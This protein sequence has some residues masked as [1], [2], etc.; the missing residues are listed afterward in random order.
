MITDNPQ[1]PKT[2][3]S[4]LSV[5]V[6]S[7]FFPLMSNFKLCSSL[8][9]IA[10]CKVNRE[11]TYYYSPLRNGLYI[12]EDCY[13]DSLVLSHWN[14][15]EIQ[16]SKSDTV[17]QLWPKQHIE[18]Q[19]DCFLCPAAYSPV[20]ISHSHVAFFFPCLKAFLFFSFLFCHSTQ[21]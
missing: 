3:Y 8:L 5:Y 9:F 2:I 16:Y 10:L 19:K 17:L 18:E 20:Y 1:S 6:L 14:L 12:S 13:Y 21:M 11:N 7:D 15:S 4:S